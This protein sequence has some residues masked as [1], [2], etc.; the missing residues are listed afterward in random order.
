MNKV[1]TVD[2]LIVELNLQL[3]LLKEWKKNNEAALELAAG[4]CLDESDGFDDR[5]IEIEEHFEREYKI[6]FD[7][8]GEI[9]QD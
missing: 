2:G 7:S 3:R 1:E 9:Y 4:D 6:K 8:Y 5:C